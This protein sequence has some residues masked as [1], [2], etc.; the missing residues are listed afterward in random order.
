MRQD[1]LPHG[2]ATKRLA[3]AAVLIVVFGGLAVQQLSEFGPSFAIDPNRD[4]FLQRAAHLA[5]IALAFLLLAWVIPAA[6]RGKILA[7]KP[8]WQ[9]WGVALLG[10]PLLGLLASDTLVQGVAMASAAL[11][12]APEAVRVQVAD[13]MPGYV[14]GDC[15]DGIDIV[16]EPFRLCHVPAPFRHRLIKGEMLVLT[17]RGSS[18]GLYVAT[19]TRAD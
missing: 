16:G 4:N 8:R 19:I 7:G 6:A 5:A 18:L 2:P 17:G 9:R 10:P 13:P 1:T 3:A 15:S 14:R 11:T 12:A